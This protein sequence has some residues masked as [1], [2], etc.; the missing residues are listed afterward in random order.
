VE[1]AFLLSIVGCEYGEAGTDVW[2]VGRGGYIE[3]VYDVAII[4]A[5]DL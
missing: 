5:L 2:Q 1:A 4:E 3:T